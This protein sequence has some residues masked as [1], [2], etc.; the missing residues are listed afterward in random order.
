MC[1]RDSYH[2]TQFLSGYGNF[3]AY[4]HRVGNMQSPTCQYLSLIHILCS[5]W[6][7]DRAIWTGFAEDSSPVDVGGDVE[8]DICRFTA[9]NTEAAASHPADWWFCTE[10]TSAVVEYRS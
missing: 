9:A 7:K 5:W 6:C 4:L 8:E 3:N 1:I 2:L 10:D